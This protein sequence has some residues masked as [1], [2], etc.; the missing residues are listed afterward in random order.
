MMMAEVGVASTTSSPATRSSSLI[1][2]ANLIKQFHPRY[3]VD[4]R[5][6]KT[7]PY[8]ALTLG[9]PFPAIK[10]TREKHRAGTRYFGPYTDAKAARE[11]IDVVRRVYPICRT[12]CVEWKRVT[13]HDGEPD[14]Q[15]VLRLPRRARARARAS[16]RSRAR[17]TPS[18]SRKVTAFLEGRHGGR[19]R[20][21]RRR[22]CASASAELD[23]ERAARLRNSA[24]RRAQG[25]R[26]ADRRVRASRSTWT[27]SASSARR[28]SRACTCSPCARAACSRATSS[29]STRGSTSRDAELVEGF[30]LRYY[31]DASHVP[32]EVVARRRCRATSEAARGVAERPARHEGRASPCR[33]AATKVAPARARDHERAPRARALQVPHPLRRGAHQRGAAPARERAGAARAAAAHRVLRHLDAARASLRRLDGGLRRRAAGH[34]RSTGGSACALDDARGERRRDDARG[35]A[36]PVRARGGR[37]QARSRR[38]RTSSSSTAGSRSWAPRVAALRG[39]RA[40]RHAGRRAREARGGAVRARLGRAGRAAGG[41]AVAVPRQARPRRGAPLRDHLPPRRCAAR[42]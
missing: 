6:D 32:K 24:R 41:L 17:S 11:T 4:Y 28:R 33:S 22:A 29:C 19:G 10:Y 5:D 27:S 31:A 16:A 14:G 8:I 35:A 15:A 20:R 30:L 38:G 40:R 3:N 34:R 39:A 12:D 1:L 36:P 9:D 25:A 18:R 42:R 26:A 37:G 23:F 13:A 2:E 21:A 7:Y